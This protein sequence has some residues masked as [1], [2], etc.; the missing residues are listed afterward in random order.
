MQLTRVRIKLPCCGSD[1]LKDRY[2]YTASAAIVKG[3][4]KIT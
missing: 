2:N 1:R 3:N 4:D